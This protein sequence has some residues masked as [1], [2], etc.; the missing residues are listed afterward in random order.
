MGS[1]FSRLFGLLAIVL[2]IVD[3]GKIANAYDTLYVSIQDGANSGLIDKIAPGG[4]VST[5]VSGLNNPSGLAFASDG[6][7]FASVAPTESSVVVDRISPTGSVTAF[8]SSIPAAYL[9]GL[10]FDSFGNLYVGLDGDGLEQVTPDGSTNRFGTALGQNVAFDSGGNLFSAATVA[11]D[12]YVTSPAGNSQILHSMPSPLGLAFDRIGDLFVSEKQADTILEY[13]PS[14]GSWVVY[15][16]LA[17]SVTP[18]PAGLQVS[19]YGLTFDSSGT[20]FVAESDGTTSAI[21]IVSAAGTIN[22]Y[23]TL[24]GVATFIADPSVTLVP[25]PLSVGLFASV[26]AGCLLRR[27][28]R[29]GRLPSQRGKRTNRP[30]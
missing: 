28:R 9:H 24:P 26:A 25:E 17:N 19:L 27:R 7:L 14:G 2:L 4:E 1:S 23:V 22:T 16:S 11:E 29:N 5:F 3:S 21:G 18:F 13:A 12:I 8:T 20:L 6:D 15:A 30:N 10:A